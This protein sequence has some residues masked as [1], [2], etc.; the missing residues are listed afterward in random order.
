MGNASI[1]IAKPTC[2]QNVQNVRSAFCSMK[3]DTVMILTVLQEKLEIVRS[4]TLDMNLERISFATRS[5]KAVELTTLKIHF[6][7]SAIKGMLWQRD[8]AKRPKMK[9]V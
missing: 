1:Q 4:A 5:L 8:S 2:I 9:D 6:V 3:L 7:L